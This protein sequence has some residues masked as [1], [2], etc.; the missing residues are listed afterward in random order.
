MNMMLSSGMGFLGAFS[1]VAI[2]SEKETVL[3]FFPFL[4]SLIFHTLVVPPSCLPLR[5]G[6]SPLPRQRLELMQSSVGV[7]PNS[8]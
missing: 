1:S 8:L 7:V 4:F 3:T 6:D 2:G 5:G